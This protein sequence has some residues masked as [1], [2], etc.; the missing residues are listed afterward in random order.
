MWYETKS[1]DEAVDFLCCTEGMDSQ[2]S[3]ET[4]TTT[5]PRKKPK[6]AYE[7]LDSDDEIESPKDKV[8]PEP[9]TDF[10]P[11]GR[12]LTMEGELASTR[13]AQAESVRQRAVDNQA[14]ARINDREAVAM[15][16]GYSPTAVVKLDSLMHTYYEI[17][18]DEA[19]IRQF[20]SRFYKKRIRELNEFTE[21]PYREIQR[22]VDREWEFLKGELTDGHMILAFW[23]MVVL[24]GKDYY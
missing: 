10:I 2:D 9:K 13:M 14:R 20:K 12:L 5:T 8:E 21:K 22:V 16:P 23:H 18:P 1:L 19:M 15:F 24:A 6:W 17:I 11:S 4:H 3:Q 7:E